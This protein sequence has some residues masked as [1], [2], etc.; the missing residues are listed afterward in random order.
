MAENAA[1][2]FKHQHLDELYKCSTKL[3]GGKHFPGG[4]LQLFLA[5]ILFFPLP[6]ASHPLCWGTALIPRHQSLEKGMFSVSEHFK[7]H[8]FAFLE[9]QQRGMRGQHCSFARL[10]EQRGLDIRGLCSAKECCD[11]NQPKSQP[12]ALLLVLKQ[13]RRTAIYSL[14]NCQR[15]DFQTN[16]RTL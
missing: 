5:L 15:Q 12:V 13:R 2:L 11:M 1:L 9:D 6:L 4:S 10:G 16:R 8:C 3:C 7:Y 14:P